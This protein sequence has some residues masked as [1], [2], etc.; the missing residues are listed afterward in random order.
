VIVNLRDIE[1]QPEPYADYRPIFLTGRLNVTHVRIKP[2][3]T[4]PEHIHE[5]EDQVYHLTSGEGFVE[6]DGQRTAVTVGSSVLIPLGTRHA[7]TNSGSDPLDY[8][9]FVVFVPER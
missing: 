6:L 2:G 3:Q 8:V 5:D 4:V 7:I 9:F 1:A